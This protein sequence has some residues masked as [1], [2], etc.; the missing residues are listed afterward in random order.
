MLY[1]KIS[2]V[3]STCHDQVIVGAVQTI[4][5]NMIACE[6]TGQ[7]LH[8]LQSCGFGGLWRF[9]GPFAKCNRTAESAELFVNCLEA[10]VE[11]CL[12]TE[13]NDSTINSSSDLSSDIDKKSND[14]SNSVKG[15]IHS[16][17]VAHC[18]RVEASNLITKELVII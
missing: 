16:Q 3:L 7:Q 4:I 11:M 15:K 6:D 17:D 13:D 5:Q 1:A 10:M 18:Q 9:A 14:K 2:S 8:Y 12:P